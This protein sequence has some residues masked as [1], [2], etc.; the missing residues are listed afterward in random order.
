LWN[1]NRSA[2]FEQTSAEYNQQ[3]EAQ[4]EQTK[5]IAR[6]VISKAFKLTL[7]KTQK[8]NDEKATQNKRGPSVKL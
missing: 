5:K 7:D 6:N 8:N 1:F 4:I 2:E 3:F